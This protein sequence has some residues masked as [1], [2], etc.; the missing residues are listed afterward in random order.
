[1][2]ESNKLNFTQVALKA[3]PI[4]ASGRVDY[5]DTQ[6][7]G[8]Q[9]RVSS[10]GTKTF[11]VYRRVKGGAPKRPSIGP[12]PAFA[13][14]QARAQARRL[15]VEM[16]SGIDVTQQRRAATQ[17]AKLNTVYEEHTLAYLCD[18]YADYLESLERVSH[19]EVRCLFNLHIKQ[20][21]PKIAAL[22]ARDITSDQIADFMRRLIKAGKGRTSNILRSYL[23]AAY[24]VARAA[25]TK[26]SISESFKDFGI[27]SNPAADTFPDE[28]QNRPDKN[29]LTEDQ[30]RAYWS[31]IHGTLTFK[32][33]A[34]RVHLLT[35]SQRIAQL[36]R[37]RTEHALK[38]QILL[39]DGKGRSGRPAREHRVPLIE[40]A[41]EAL[42]LCYPSGEF[43][44]ST[45]GG[46]THIDAQTLSGWAVDIVGDSI[47]N[48]QLKRVRSGVETL[49][50]KAKISSEIR[51]RLQSH[52]IAGVQARHYDGYDYMDD[53]RDALLTLYRLLEHPSSTPF[54]RAA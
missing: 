43:A 44:L 20:A 10:T 21:W 17:E 46:D 40:P 28:S 33:A 5:Y 41:A 6:V 49:L 12:F 29:P 45:D 47:P 24:Q 52:G 7:K 9:L 42:S 53:K 37:L 23:H 18:S 3:L 35:G 16:A 54:A 31:I 27:T 48:F 39:F 50:A 25:K 22:P 38:D 30:L 2:A 15:I 1:M 51:G 32:A 13:V 34:L 26:P 19:N 14:E 11:F 36:V 8:L 4:P